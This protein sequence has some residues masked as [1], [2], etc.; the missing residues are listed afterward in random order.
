MV[1]DPAD[2]KGIKFLRTAGWT[3]ITVRIS[4]IL[5]E[6][7]LCEDA[8]FELLQILTAPGD[9]SLPIPGRGL[10]E[11]PQGSTMLLA[12]WDALRNVLMLKFSDPQPGPDR[13]ID[14]LCRNLGPRFTT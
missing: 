13:D 4:P 6:K 3:M 12:Q 8:I 14:I 2:S 9:A 7:W 11:N 10:W 1:H 5:I